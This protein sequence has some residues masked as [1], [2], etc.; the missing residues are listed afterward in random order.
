MGDAQCGTLEISRIP[1]KGILRRKRSGTYDAPVRRIISLV[2]S[3]LVGSLI[4]GACSSP[5]VSSETTTSQYS[6]L[7]DTGLV[8]APSLVANTYVSGVIY[9]QGGP[10]LTDQFGRTIYLHGVNAVYKHAPYTLTITPGKPNSF[11]TWD[12]ESIAADGFN[13]VRLGIIWAGIEP[14][15]GGP[16]QPA[17]CTPGAP[18]DPHMWNQAKANAYLNQVEQV[19]NLLGRFHIYALLDMHQDIWSSVFSGEGAP[20]WATCTSGNPVVIYPGRWSNNYSNPAVD[21]SFH[22][23]FYNSVQGDLQG[24]YDRAWHAVAERF[25]NNPSVIGYDPINEPLALQ[26]YKGKGGLLYAQGLSCLYGGSGGK[27]WELNSNAIVPCPSSVPRIG[28]VSMLLRTDTNHLIFPEV[29]N[30]SDAGKTLFI[31]RSTDYERLVYN[32]HDYCQQRSGQTGNPTDLNQ[33]GDTVLNQLISEAQ[34]RPLYR[35]AAQPGGPAEVMTEF[36]ATSSQNLAALMVNAT[37]TVGL[38]WLWWAW[39]YYDDPTGSSAEALV[40]TPGNTYS[41]AMNPLL[42]TRTVAVAG[43]VLAS[44]HAFPTDLYN[45]TYLANASTQ[46]TVI[47]IAP[48]AY[49][50]TGYCTYATGATITSKPRSQY[51]TVKNAFPGAVVSVR[52]E[53][54]HCVSGL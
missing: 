43:T 27:T 10:F 23:F 32:F 1:H 30:A 41:P 12:A 20:A 33:C 26:P 47:W 50:A 34:K 54:G 9:S 48:N 36:G 52:I 51:V 17:I 22:N 49:Q 53:P 14:G 39:R 3:I 25:K 38:S 18:H 16:N 46:P 24:E 15:H 5:S 31:T 8:A 40:S 37:A 19:V 28:L 13:I 21:A 6:K 4:L 45:L 29:D 2:A 35:S 42:A 44:E 11:T 7:R